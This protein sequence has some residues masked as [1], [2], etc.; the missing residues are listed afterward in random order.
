MNVRAFTGGDVHLV[1]GGLAVEGMGAG[2]TGIRSGAMA[3]TGAGVLT[4]AG[5][6][7]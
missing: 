1:G 7:T 5:A 3:G 6:M 4:R 2:S